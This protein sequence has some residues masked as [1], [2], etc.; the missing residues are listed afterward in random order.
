MQ[1]RKQN[2]LQKQKTQKCHQHM[3]KHITKRT[4][5]LPNNSQNHYQ[6][7]TKTITNQ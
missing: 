6:T 4:K 7:I 3:T 2:I 5:I 1:K